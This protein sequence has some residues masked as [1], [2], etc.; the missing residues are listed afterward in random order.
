MRVWTINNRDGHDPIKIRVA[1]PLGRECTMS[2]LIKPFKIKVQLNHNHQV[3]MGFACI[4]PALKEWLFRIFETMITVQV[5]TSAQWCPK[6]IF[7]LRYRDRP[8][9]DGPSPF[10]SPIKLLVLVGWVN[11]ELFKTLTRN[12]RRSCHSSEWCRSVMKDWK[13][14]AWVSRSKGWWTGQI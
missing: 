13:V 7:I 4:S 14:F 9:V 2:T 10:A 3:N 5:E 1:R 8:E 12:G 6:W 11:D